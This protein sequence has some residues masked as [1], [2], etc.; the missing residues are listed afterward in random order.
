MTSAYPPITNVAHRAGKDGICTRCQARLG[1]SI[2]V[3]DD[4]SVVERPWSVGERIVEYDC[5]D[6][7]SRFSDHV[8]GFAI[9]CIP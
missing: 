5:P 4:G 2:V 6:G 1:N 7:R 9:D 8:F 3:Q